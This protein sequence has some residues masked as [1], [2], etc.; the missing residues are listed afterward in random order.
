MTAVV[1]GDFVSRALPMPVHQ[2]HPPPTALSILGLA[3]ALALSP[4]LV[5]AEDAGAPGVEASV[6]SEVAGTPESTAAESSPAAMSD[7]SATTGDDVGP[8]AESVDLFVSK[9]ASC[10]TIGSGL[11]VGPD[12]KGVSERRS[13]DWLARMIQTPSAM[14]T[15]DAE[16]RKLLLEF[17]NVKMPDLG[18]TSDQAQTMIDLIDYCSVETCDLKGKFVAVT[19]AVEDDVRRGLG[20]F[21]GDVAMESGGPPCISC[22][23]VIGTA[24]SIGGGLLAADL[25]YVFAR[26]GD[27]GLDASLRNP[28]FPLMNRVFSDKPL[29]ADETFALRAFLYQ[30]NRG[31]MAEIVEP[32]DATSALLLGSL[33]AIIALVLLNAAWSGRLR[34]ARELLPKEKGR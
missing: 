21:V 29:T 31:A 2:M 22:H 15:S 4:T 5:P 26:L 11:R 17:N 18:L 34:N 20:L 30:A 6:S 7:S 16:A 13:G 9:C 24:A 10:H 25:T 33:G 1:V 8:P 28:A 27:E 14:L 19:D 12:L 32:H 23:N 3:L